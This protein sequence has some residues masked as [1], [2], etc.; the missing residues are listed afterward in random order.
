MISSKDAIIRQYRGII[1]TLTDTS[2]LELEH[3]RQQNE[4]DVVEGLIRRLIAENA[5]VG[6]DPDDYTRREA[7]LLAR[8]DAAKASMTSIEAQIQERKSRRTKLATFI[9]ALEKQ[10]GLITEFDERL[11]NATLESVTVYE[12]DRIV[13]TIKGGLHFESRI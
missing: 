10:D 2:A 3:T 9:R 5:Q 8:Y 12:Q 1:K 11:W 13:F 4:Y 7:E 6:L